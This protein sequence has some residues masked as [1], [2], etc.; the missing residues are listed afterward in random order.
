ML[1]YLV[2]KCDLAFISYHDNTIWIIFA[3]QIRKVSTNSNVG[4]KLRFFCSLYLCLQE[5]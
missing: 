5:A 4:G 2:D 3:E 1:S